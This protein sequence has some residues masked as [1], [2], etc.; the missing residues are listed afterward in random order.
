VVIRKPGH[1]EAVE[2]LLEEE[3]ISL[4]GPSSRVSLFSYQSETLSISSTLI[5]E[6]IKQSQPVDD[7]VEREVKK[8][9][10]ENKLYE[11]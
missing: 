5:R 9:M 3:N 4:H 8:I 11:S 2:T 7:L 6:K 1:K 10:E